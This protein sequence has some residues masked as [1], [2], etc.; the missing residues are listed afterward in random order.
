MSKKRIKVNLCLFD[1]KSLFPELIN[2]N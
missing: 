2:S 1:A